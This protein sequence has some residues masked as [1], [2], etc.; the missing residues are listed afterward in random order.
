MR[1]SQAKKSLILQASAKLIAAEGYEAA[2]LKAIADASKAVIGSVVHFFDD[3]TRLADAVL[4]DIA[5]RFA[6]TLGRAL[7][8]QGKDV[9]G[10]VA[11]AI[12]AVFDWVRENPEDHLASVELGGRRLGGRTLQ[13]MLASPAVLDV[14]AAWAKPLIASNQMAAM[15]ER[16]IT[17]VMLG[18][19]WAIAAPRDRANAAD[20]VVDPALLGRLTTAALAALAPSPAA[21]K[22]SAQAAKRQPAKAKATNRQ[23]SLI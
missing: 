14:V 3:K 22:G 21:D 12:R 6:A 11:D 23:G 15:G 13:Q 19:A 2:T 10:A 16:S 18:S 7:Q 17:A 1:N 8:G 5:G 9:E 20:Q 4:A